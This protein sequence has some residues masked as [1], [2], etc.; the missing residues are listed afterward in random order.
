MR[1]LAQSRNLKVRLLI[2]GAAPRCVRVDIMVDTKLPW[3]KLNSTAVASRGRRAH[4]AGCPPRGVALMAA[5]FN[6]P[7]ED[8]GAAAG[9]GGANTGSVHAR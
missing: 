5:F 7:I 8:L 6:F 2:K 4:P 1:L 9:A 3:T